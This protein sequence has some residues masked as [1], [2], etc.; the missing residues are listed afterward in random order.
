M[1]GEMV[2]IINDGGVGLVMMVMGWN[3]YSE[4]D[5]WPRF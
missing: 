2:K 3:S 1:N 4:D 5:V